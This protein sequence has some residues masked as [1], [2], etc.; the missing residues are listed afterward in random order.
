MAVAEVVALMVL[1]VAVAAADL[2][3]TV[4]VSEEEDAVVAVAVSATAAVVET[5]QTD[6]KGVSLKNPVFSPIG[7][8]KMKTFENVFEATHLSCI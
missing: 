3:G 2:A 7:K 8:L 6:Q 5:R 4:A 1:A